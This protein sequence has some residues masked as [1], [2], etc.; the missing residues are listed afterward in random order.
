MLIF[1]VGNYGRM[2]MWL[3]AFDFA[4]GERRLGVNQ[5]S[6]IET[7]YEPLSQE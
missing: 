1:N 2:T 4:D 3:I 5:T 7:S 6:V